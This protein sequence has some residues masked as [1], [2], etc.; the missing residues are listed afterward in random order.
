MSETE[1]VIGPLI[2]AFSPPGVEKEKKARLEPP[3]MA[4]IKD[5]H[6]GDCYNY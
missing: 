6:F 2:P 5:I 4:S 1:R 3:P